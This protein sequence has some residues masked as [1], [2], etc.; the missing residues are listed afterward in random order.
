MICAHCHDRMKENEIDGACGM[1]G[2]GRR[3][4]RVLVEETDRRRPL[5]KTQA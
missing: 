2:G 3:E 4:Y 1:R 5:W